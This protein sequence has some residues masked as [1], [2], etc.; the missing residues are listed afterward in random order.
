M[1]Q[2]TSRKRGKKNTIHENPREAWKVGQL[3]ICGTLGT[4]SGNE[5]VS[6]R[7]YPATAARRRAARLFVVC[8]EHHQYGIQRAI[9]LV[10]CWIDSYFTTASG[11]YFR[12]YGYCM[13]SH[14]HPLSP[15]FLINFLIPLPFP[16]SVPG[17]VSIP[18][19]PR[20]ESILRQEPK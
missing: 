5:K 17:K 16:S 14:N 12:G 15:L 9:T 13:N 18:R 8:P 1:V 11:R 19:G 2:T 10:W 20:A 3:Q 7:P 6:I 4:M